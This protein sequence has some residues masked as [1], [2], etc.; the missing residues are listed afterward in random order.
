LRNCR[1]TRTANAASTA[2][3]PSARIRA[4]ISRERLRKED[5]MINDSDD[6]I[7]IKAEDGCQSVWLIA[8]PI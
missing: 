6:R 2:P 8:D 1:A 3:I 5:F 7:A 4:R